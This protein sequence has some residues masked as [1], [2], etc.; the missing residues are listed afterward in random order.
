[1]SSV[2]TAAD[3]V[4]V[5]EAWAPPRLAM[6]GDPVGLQLGRLDKPVETVWLALDT[7]LPVVQEAVAAGAD[8]LV[9]HHELF[10]RPLP[11]L[12]TTTIK[13]RT[14]A[15]ALAH[16]LTIY[17]AHTNLDV[18]EGGVNDVLAA[19]L[20]LTD[21]DILDRLQD[22][23]LR[24]LVVFVPESHH[25]QVLQ[26]VCAAGAGH[27][28]R[29]SHCTFNTPGEGTFLPLPG[30]QPF[31]GQV[32][33]LERAAEVRLETVVPE[34]RLEAVVR[35]MLAAHP[36]EE[37]AYD[38]YPLEIMG[39][40]YGIGRIGNLEKPLP[41]QEFAAQVRDALGLSHI[42]FGGEPDKRVQRVAVL[43]GSGGKWA[44]AAL[45]KGADVF[46]TSDCDHHTVADAWLDGLAI[47]D[48]THA[49]LE[50]PV[51]EAMR[52]QLTDRLP[53]LSV[54]ISEVREDPFT[55]L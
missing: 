30:T 2:H 47:I 41:L 53:G 3:V 1:M 18:A 34:S 38:V 10:Y 43:G 12:D 14:I 39:K 29:Y 55:W 20:G 13:G 4:R 26:A 9:T 7:S 37:V 42:R 46:V 49:A 51:L 32:G 21:V 33:Q 31:L 22:D 16:D 36:Y 11:K 45:A 6:P 19:K 40:A 15:E 25:E 48:A 50:R 8:M 44:A 28:G 5:L 24:K 17:A 23:R 35:A 27:I 52:Q 54:R